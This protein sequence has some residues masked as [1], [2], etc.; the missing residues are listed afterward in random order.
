MFT[1]LYFASGSRR[2][3]TAE[4]LNGAVLDAFYAECRARGEEIE[5]EAQAC[6]PA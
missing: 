3:P 6:V 4:G 1:W 5:A 2:L